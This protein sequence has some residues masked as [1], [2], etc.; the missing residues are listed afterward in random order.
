V[1]LRPAGMPPGALHT[2]A[3]TTILDVKVAAAVER[4]GGGRDS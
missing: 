4:P 2:A 3:P 1:V